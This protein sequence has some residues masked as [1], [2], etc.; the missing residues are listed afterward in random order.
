MP[1]PEQYLSPC[2]SAPERPVTRARPESQ[3]FQLIVRDQRVWLCHLLQRCSKDK[4][5]NTTT[6]CIP[7]FPQTRLFC[8]VL[9]RCRRSILSISNTLPHSR[10]AAQMIATSLEWAVSALHG[11]NLSKH[12][13]FR[14]LH[15]VMEALFIIVRCVMTLPG[16]YEAQDNP[17]KTTSGGCS[18]H[19]VV[20]VKKRW[21]MVP[22]FG[23]CGPPS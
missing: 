3:L 23:N 12:L 1:L 7:T 22:T 11:R 13:A 17:A 18:G 16:T 10:R 4:T 19:H 20:A 6:Q 8:L 21:S 9:V 5:A 2:R 15:G 14:Q